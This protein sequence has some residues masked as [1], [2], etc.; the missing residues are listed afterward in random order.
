MPIFNPD[1]AERQPPPIDV[2]VHLC[3]LHIWTGELEEF[4]ATSGLDAEKANRLR[5]RVAR[6]AYGEY[7]IMRIGG[8]VLS[9]KRIPS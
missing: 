9:V 2:D 6:L 7:Y 5:L 4:I 1:D 8:G 3:T